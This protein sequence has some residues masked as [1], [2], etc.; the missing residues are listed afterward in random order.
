MGCSMTI[1]AVLHPIIPLTEPEPEL[2][3]TVG[4]DAIPFASM[5]EA[6]PIARGAVSPPV[7]IVARV[8]PR[9]APA[10]IMLEYILPKSSELV[11]ICIPHEPPKKY[12]GF[13]L[14]AISATH[15]PVRKSKQYLRVRLFPI[16]SLTSKECSP[17]KGRCAVTFVNGL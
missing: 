7:A 13:P 8:L 17:T 11:G 1:N 12:L 2:N 5:L 10:D 16:T 6:E 3:W 14:T 9:V 4:E 15:E